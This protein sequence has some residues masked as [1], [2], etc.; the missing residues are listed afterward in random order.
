M[1]KICFVKSAYSQEKILYTSLPNVTKSLETELGWES[2]KD[3]AD[4]LGL[5]LFHKIHCNTTRPLIKE[6]MPQ[7][8]SRQNQPQSVVTYSHFPYKGVN[9]ANSYF[10]YFTR[11][12]NNLP[13]SLK[14]KNV[15]DFKLELKAMIKP[16]R[17]K[18]YSRGDK[19]KNSLL[20]RI[21]VGR[22][23]L[24]DHSFAIG[25]AQ[26]MFCEKC[27][28]PRENSLHFI[29]QCD[30]YSDCRLVLLNRVKE[31]IPN[32]HLLPKKRQYEILVH[33]YDKDNDDLNSYN[34]KIMIATQNFIYD[35]KRF[36]SKKNPPP[37][38]PQPPPPHVPPAAP[39]VISH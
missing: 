19:Y 13:K 26:N 27:L 38:P 23:L 20:T 22:S 4:F 1:H 3:R 34:T 8:S 7:Y 24:N 29:T 21:R 12:W 30:F 35:T 14:K 9:F 11:K 18:F 31:F 37:P 16:K 17:Y 33:G 28:F 10:P 39:P 5:T 32:I 25:F 2:I 6:C 15:D 36:C